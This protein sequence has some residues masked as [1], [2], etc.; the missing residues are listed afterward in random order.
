MK[1]N[2]MRLLLSAAVCM[3]AFLPVHAEK[4]HLVWLEKDGK[5]YWL[6]NGEVQG[7]YGDPK[8]I[9]DTV[10]GLE[11][12]RE[13][14]D[15]ASDGW[16]WLDA[17]YDGAKAENKE[18]WM[19][20]IF[21]EDLVTGI[22]KQGKW[23]R[24]DANG[25][26]IKGW[27][28]VASALDREL[29][30]DQADNTYY[31]DLITG[32]MVKGEREIDGRTYQFDALTGVLAQETE[33]EGCYGKSY[34][35]YISTSYGIEAEIPSGCLFVATEDYDGDAQ[36]EV[37]RVLLDESDNI[38]LEILEK[39]Q[40]GEYRKAGSY[41]TGIRLPLSPSVMTEQS[42]NNLAVFSFDDDQGDR[43]IAVEV[44]DN[45]GFMSDGIRREFAV[46][47]YD[48]TLTECAKADY[49]GS[50]WRFLYGGQTITDNMLKGN[51]S[52]L[53]GSWLG[54]DVHLYNYASGIHMIGMLDAV[55]LLKDA[56]HDRLG[57]EVLH[58]ADLV[59][60]TEG[61]CLAVENAVN[62][63]G[64]QLRRIKKIVKNG[65]ILTFTYADDSVY[66]TAITYTGG[67]TKV[68]VHFEM[69]EN[70]KVYHAF[71]RRDGQKD[72][73]LDSEFAAYPVL[74]KDKLTAVYGE[75]PYFA[76]MYIRLSENI[77]IYQVETEKWYGGY[78]LFVTDSTGKNMLSDTE[79][80]AFFSGV[81][82]GT[83]ATYD[84]GGYVTAAERIEV[85][86]ETVR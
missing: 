18:V 30:P 34:P 11:R 3:T 26:M 8:N 60:S 17:V 81:F 78:Y 51:V 56:D 14:Y 32:E 45:S 20:Y 1:H 16:Y 67:E 66:P 68:T 21:Q 47:M 86:Y 44:S 24:Y 85:E 72:S 13:I 7:V 6:E 71:L 46:A 19:P 75:D 15:P 76:N 10:Y 61:Q 41:D 64:R 22:N 2:G 80:D 52:A 48:G 83:D 35:A 63:A 50:D 29:Y 70:H 58:Y 33:S 38:S 37:L 65:T 73:D 27:Y 25:K 12:G 79:T 55:Q 31:Y 28:T 77:Y 42:M 53:F 69:D 4:D 54:N 23:V 57:R 59:F 84:D 49:N 9:R 39:E 5:Q 82:L 36:D 43:R 62:T 40:S 74:S